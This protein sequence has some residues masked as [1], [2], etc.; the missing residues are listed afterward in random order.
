MSTKRSGFVSRL[1]PGLAKFAT[2]A[3]AAALFAVATAG[4]VRAETRTLK[5]Y[6]THTH[7]TASITFKKNGRYVRSGL[8]DLNRF[9]RDWRRNESIKMDPRLFDLIWQ[10]YRRARTSKPIHVVSG[11]RSPATNNMLRRRSRGV[12]KFSQHTLGKAMDFFIPGVSSSKIRALGMQQQVGGVGYYPR[13]RS[14]FI[15][16]DTGRVRHWPRM[17]RRQLVKVFPRGNTLH[18]PRDGKPLA[19]YKVA[20][21]RAKSGKSLA[22]RSTRV[23]SL[24]SPTASGDDWNDGVLRERGSGKGFLSA[25]FGGGLDE[26]EESASGFETTRVAAAKRS[27]RTRTAKVKTKK[28]VKPKAVR[29]AAKT[30][31]APVPPGNV[32]DKGVTRVAALAPPT[33]SLTGQSKPEPAKESP[34]S[35]VPTPA[36]TPATVTRKDAPVP[37]AKPTILVATAETPATTTILPQAKPQLPTQVAS[38][39]ETP[40]DETTTA[41]VPER[42]PS[43]ATLMA[44]AS[45]TA[46]DKP[47]SVLDATRA[48]ARSGSAPVPPRPNPRLSN[49]SI[50]KGDIGTRHAGVA[51]TIETDSDA[52]LTLVDRTSPDQPADPRV[53]HISK[54]A[55]TTA[56]AELHHPD[57]RRLADLIDLPDRTLRGGFSQ[58]AMANADV[59]TFHGTAIATLDT[60]RFN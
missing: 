12:A 52:G 10:V 56:F 24:T 6:N 47:Q 33:I 29:V 16:L 11:Y 59:G 45:P 14:R 43:T 17:S 19:G 28:T 54:S 4:S 37:L 38:A 34:T 3:I 51:S 40:V 44:Y 9:L 60:R 49:R 21:A 53:F 31:S 36:A 8:R 30:P 27:K 58:A 55:G 26:E 20:L 48:F 7:E 39:D 32:G 13:S 35:L 5:L 15:H 2:I 57:Q 50:S 1:T 41:T 25:L 22:R 23:A 18:V 46:E 42:K